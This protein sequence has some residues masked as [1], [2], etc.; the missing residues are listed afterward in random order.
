MPV[1]PYYYC[2]TIVTAAHSNCGYMFHSQVEFKITQLSVSGLKVNRLDMYGEVR[3][4]I[5]Q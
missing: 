1:T 3:F 2:N 5:A 4:C